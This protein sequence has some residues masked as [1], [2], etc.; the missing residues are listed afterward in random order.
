MTLHRIFSESG[1]H[2]NTPVFIL[3]DRLHS[4]NA[5]NRM[6]VESACL[7]QGITSHRQNAGMANGLQDFAIRKLIVKSLRTHPTSSSG[8]FGQTQEVFGLDSLKRLTST[9]SHHISHPP[10][11]DDYMPAVH[12]TFFVQKLII[13]IKN[14]PTL[15]IL[16]E[17]YYNGGAFFRIYEMPASAFKI[18]PHRS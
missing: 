5:S 13:L 4:G 10:Y 16:S 17:W 1:P 6:P 7:S 3:L 15:L 14:T 12:C 9:S 2:K 18:S 11:R 8:L